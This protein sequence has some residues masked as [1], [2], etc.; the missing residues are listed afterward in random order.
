MEPEQSLQLQIRECLTGMGISS[1]VDWDVLV[2]V[3]RHQRS[4]ANAEQIARMVGYPATMVRESLENL[5]SLKLLR[6]SRA[7]RGV[8]LYQFASSLPDSPSHDYFRQLIASVENRAGRLEVIRELRT[9][10]KKGS[11]WLKA[12]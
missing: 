2:F 9:A 3:Y 12:G 5:E 6:R 10:G 1:P 4:L 11:K 8:S 7:S